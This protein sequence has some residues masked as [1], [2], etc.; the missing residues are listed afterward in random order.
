MK[1]PE[2]SPTIDRIAEPCLIANLSGASTWRQRQGDHESSA[3]LFS[4]Q[5]KEERK[6]Q[7]EVGEGR[8]EERR[9][10]GKGGTKSLSQQDESGSREMEYTTD[11][12]CVHRGKMST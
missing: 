1:I 8:R 3:S 2:R 4:T 11:D 12:E 7:K 10:R 5:K 9:G 6:E